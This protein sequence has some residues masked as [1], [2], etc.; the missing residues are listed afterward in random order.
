[1]QGDN[2]TARCETDTAETQNQSSEDWTEVAEEKAKCASSPDHLLLGPME[3]QLNQENSMHSV[4]SREIPQPTV[5]SSVLLTT[6][7]NIQRNLPSIHWPVDAEIS[8]DLDMTSSSFSIWQSTEAGGHADTNYNGSI[9]TTPS[10]N[11]LM[12]MQRVS[13]QKSASVLDTSP[14]SA[15]RPGEARVTA[16]IRV[17]FPPGNAIFP[18]TFSAHLAACEFFIKQNRAYK[19]RTQ[20]GGSEA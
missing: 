9:T 4:T 5:A 19:Q 14:S 2:L 12:D 16:E 3:E 7:A 13:F 1:L 6:D 8:L 15:S 10:A 17:A 20:L 18:S 11:L